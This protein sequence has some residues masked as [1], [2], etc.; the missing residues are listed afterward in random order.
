M[1]N[2]RQQLEDDMSIFHNCNEFAEMKEIVYNGK[3]YNILV[4]IDSEIAKERNKPSSDNA[5][6]IFLIDTVIFAAY[7]DLKIM[8]KKGKNIEIDGEIYIIASV[9]NEC[10]EIELELMRYDE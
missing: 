2:F 3:F 9:S 10:G 1:I 4:V 5:D 7:K 8:P 6:G